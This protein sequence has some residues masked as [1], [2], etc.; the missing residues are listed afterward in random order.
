MLII[1][2]FVMMK[3]NVRNN[4]VLYEIERFRLIFL[5]LEKK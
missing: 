5:V 1:H 4:T 3:K 2:L